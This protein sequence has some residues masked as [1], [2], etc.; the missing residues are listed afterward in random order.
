M[1]NL[2]D[3]IIDLLNYIRPLDD[4]ILREKIFTNEKNYTM[5]FKPGGVEYLKEKASGY[6]SYF[7]GNIPYTFAEKIDKGIIPNGMLFTYVIKCFMKNFQYNTYLKTTL[8]FEDSL[9]RASSAAANFVFPGLN[10]EKNDIIGFYSTL[11]ETTQTHG[12]MWKTAA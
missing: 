3:D 7:R 10:K 12:G 11:Q 1:K 2:A 5:K 8:N 6:I 9:D 4:P